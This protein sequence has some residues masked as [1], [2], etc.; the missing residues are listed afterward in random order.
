MQFSFTETSIKESLKILS[1]QALKAGFPALLFSK[2]N[3][4]EARKSLKA[5]FYSQNNN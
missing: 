3:S 5:F 1:R 2:M 4:I